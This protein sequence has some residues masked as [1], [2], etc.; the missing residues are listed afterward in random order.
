LLYRYEMI[1]YKP[2]DSDPRAAAGVRLPR[3]M[4]EFLDV[5]RLYRFIAGLVTDDVCASI[6]RTHR[7]S[8][9]AD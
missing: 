7:W 6:P 2:G 8:P 1:V 9:S 5:V 3:G 4:N